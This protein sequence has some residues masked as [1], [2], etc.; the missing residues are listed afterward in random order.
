MDA[1][2]RIDII[3]REKNISRRRLAILLNIAPSTFG[4]MFLRRNDLSASTAEEISK[5]LNVP[6]NYI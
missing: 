2:N 6:L 4:S 1:Y 3:L 5:Q